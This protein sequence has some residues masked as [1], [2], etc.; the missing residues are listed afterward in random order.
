MKTNAL[1]QV[2]E[3]NAMPMP[4]LKE[5]WKAFSGRSS[6]PGTARTW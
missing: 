4:Q 5:R 1:A 3:L 6:R 2:A